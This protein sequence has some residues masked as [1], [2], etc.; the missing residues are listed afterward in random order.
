[1]NGNRRVI[2]KFSIKITDY[3][4]IGAPAG[5]EV[6]SVGLDANGDPCIWCIVDPDVEDHVDIKI[7][8]CGTGNSMF[9]SKSEFLGTIVKDRGVWHVFV[10]KDE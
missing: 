1:M 10:C 7:A 6:L 3:Q 8:V 5:A 2:Y 4:W 9:R